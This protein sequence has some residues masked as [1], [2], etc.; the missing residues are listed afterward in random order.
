MPQEQYAAHPLSAQAHVE[1][2][3]R[4]VAETGPNSLDRIL[5]NHDFPRLPQ[6]V[7]ARNVRAAALLLLPGAAVAIAARRTDRLDALAARIRAAGGTALVVEH[8][9]RDRGVREVV[10]LCGNAE[11]FPESWRSRAKERFS[12]GRLTL[13]HELARVVLAEQLY[14]ALSILAHHPYHRD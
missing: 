10:F 3:H 2:E 4:N 5:S 9:L 8:A 11:G 13:S 7:G 12:L 1:L 14:R 6:R